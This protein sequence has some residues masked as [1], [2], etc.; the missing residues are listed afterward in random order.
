[1]EQN[2][3]APL[4]GSIGS[5]PPFVT[6]EMSPDIAQCP[7]RRQSSPLKTYGLHHSFSAHL[8]SFLAPTVCSFFCCFPSSH[9]L[10]HSAT[11]CWVSACSSRGW[12]TL[13]AHPERPC[14]GPGMPGWLVSECF[15]S[16]FCLWVGC[17]PPPNLS[18]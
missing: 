12:V 3:W 11:S 14:P 18:L 6:P 2:P 13:L 5:S 16:V 10:I 9:S 15:L 4:T 1:M 17:L 7:L 8:S